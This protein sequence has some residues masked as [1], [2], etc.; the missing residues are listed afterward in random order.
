MGNKENKST[1]QMEHRAK[2]QQPLTYTHTPQ[3]NPQTLLISLSNL[4]TTSSTQLPLL[5][6][7]FSSN[8][9]IHFYLSSNSN[10]YDYS[11]S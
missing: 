9:Y 2:L 8:S 6:P 3:V 4:V 11:H 7:L 10:H 5:V 1:P